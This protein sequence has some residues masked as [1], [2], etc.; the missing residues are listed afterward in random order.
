M[1]LPV[2]ILM[3]ASGFDLST[4]AEDVYEDAIADIVG[5]EAMISEPALIKV[6]VVHWCIIKET[7][8]R[9]CRI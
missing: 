8:T 3:G 5:P 6:F 7:Q 9:F 2:A 4:M 1:K